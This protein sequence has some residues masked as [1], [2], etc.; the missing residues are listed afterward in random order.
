[1]HAAD[2]RSLSLLKFSTL[3]YILQVVSGYNNLL[4]TLPIADSG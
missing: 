2:N 1:M 3:N 4:L